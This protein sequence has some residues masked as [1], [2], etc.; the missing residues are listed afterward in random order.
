MIISRLSPR[1]LSELI[2]GYMRFLIHKLARR[3]LPMCILQQ[4]LVERIG[5][6]LLHISMGVIPLHGLGS[7]SIT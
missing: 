1:I 7:E 4:V 2:M 6:V 5:E 3:T